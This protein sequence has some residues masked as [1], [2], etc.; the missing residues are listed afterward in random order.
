MMPVTQCR[1]YDKLTVK[2]EMTLE[3]MRS[4][5]AADEVYL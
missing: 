3:N 2:V 5:G 4:F 1:E